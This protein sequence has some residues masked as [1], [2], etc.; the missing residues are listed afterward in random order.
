MYPIQERNLFTPTITL[1][2]RES[3]GFLTTSQLIDKLNSHFRPT[4]RDAN[5]LTNRSDTYFSQKV[6]NMVSH[7]SSSTSLQRRGL[8]VYDKQ[9]GG[10]KITDAGRAFIK[11]S[12]ES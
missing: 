1:L 2:S 4:G 12:Q 9:L 5:I 7:R 11:Q 10:W 3:S 6:R 8:A